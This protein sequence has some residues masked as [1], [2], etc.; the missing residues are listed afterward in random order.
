MTTQL[1]PDE[2]RTRVLTEN[3]AQSILNHLRALESNRAHM[4][5]RWIWEL[6]QNARDTS[7][8]TDTDLVVSI[9]HKP[10]EL[11]FQHN[12][13]RFK[14]DEIAHLIYHGSTKV[15]DAGTI[16]QYGSGFLT[17]HL[18]S[19][20]INISGHLDD[21]QSFVF[22]LNREIGSVQ[23]L[24]ESMDRAWEDF[25]TFSPA[26]ALGDF[27]T[28][29]R[30]P[31]E[32]DAVDAINNG[33]AMLKRCA[34]FVVVFNEKFSRIDIKT[35][36]EN[37]SFEVT[38]RSPLSQARLEKI[39]VSEHE[40]ENQN[41]KV[42]LM[43]EDE[44]TAVAIPLES[45]GD[46]QVCLPIND[47]PKL[48]LGFPIVG[49]KNFSFPAVINSFE[50]T[51]TEERDGVYIG[52]ANNDANHKNQAI[53]EGA[54]ELLVDLLQFAG[55]SRCCNTHLLTEVPAIQEQNWLNTDWLREC[56]K[57]HLIKKIRQTPAIVTE[58]GKTI[59]PRYAMLPSAAIE[60]L[61]NLWY[62]LENW[63]G[64]S[65][66]L[67][68]RSEVAGWCNAVK[69][70][71]IVSESEISSFNEVVDARKLASD[72]NEVSYDPSADATTHRLSFLKLRRGISAINWLNRL[73]AFLKNNELNEVIN[74]YRIVP[75]QEGFLRTFSNLYRD[76]GIAEELKDI[77]EL[78]EWRVRCALRD[79]GICS[80]VDEAGAG[81]WDNEYIVKELIT[82]LH[83]RVGKN[84]DDN[85]KEASVRL[86]AW[87][88]NQK[89]W[90]RLQGFPVFAKDRNSVFHLP[91]DYDGKP[92]LAPIHVWPEDLKQFADLFPPDRILADDF[93]VCD[94]EAWKQLNDQ[95]LVRNSII[96]TR[97]EMNLKNLSPDVNQEEDP[98]D[99]TQCITVTDVV[100]WDAIIRR[101]RDSRDRAFLFWRF[102]TE[103][104]IKGSV[105]DL[106]PQKADCACGETHEYYPAAWLMAVRNN[107]WIR[108]E[109]SSKRVRAD[110]QSLASLLRDKGWDPNKN[111]GTVELLEAIDVNRSDLMLGLITKNDEERNE[112]VSNMLEIHQTTQGGLS[113]IQALMPYLQEDEELI[114]HLEERQERRRIV[115]ENQ[116][117]GRRV[118]ELVKDNLKREGFSVSRTGIGSDFEISDVVTLDINKAGRS[119]LI[120]VKATRDRS[121]RLTDTQAKESVEK[122]NSFLLCVVPLDPEDTNPELDTVRAKMRFVADIGSHLAT[123]CDDLD[124]LEDFRESIT[125]STSS[126]VQLEIVSGT[127]RIRVASSVW[128]NHGFQIEDLANQLK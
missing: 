125:T 57:E 26:P 4:R 106:K 27:T 41:N 67:P 30:Y 14:I 102:L 117:L 118:E 51:P 21:G 121:V 93:K 108:L 33:L 126:G 75:S 111:P 35:P 10:R 24:S 77:A 25:N 97:S 83:E 91:I 72:V 7:V 63:H 85:F 42:Y 96:I 123:L 49:T 3:T 53:I 9:E 74:Q 87:I 86:F 73:I 11:V 119:W 38:K 50:F 55:L 34:P 120:E 82:K 20:E 89:D 66:L 5:T 56:L 43:A 46:S 76:Q 61:E 1:T 45:M 13:S 71:A 39:E 29:F 92:L 100:E 44:K 62:L 110:V 112:L 79:T 17:T 52:Q 58:A 2:I 70:W 36:N 101:V 32:D 124:D 98:H 8:D 94:P 99:S 88:V 18:L 65:E 28:Q 19:P 6:L 15:E 60:N 109:K 23:E 115:Y 40:N 80:L 84:P 47:V 68:K 116:C 22:R 104:L 64:N 114:P 122:G 113:R 90:K 78:L 128:K 95:S 103:W 107:N 69:S 12:G 59:S 105:Q 48:F 16:G 127:A 31:I 37:T 81:D 54:C